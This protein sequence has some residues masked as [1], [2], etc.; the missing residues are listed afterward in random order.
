MH[1]YNSV[2]GEARARYRHL[3]LGALLVAGFGILVPSVPVAV[4]ADS[5]KCIEFLVER[6][7]IDCVD[8]TFFGGTVLLTVALEAEVVWVRLSNI[9]EVHVDYAASA[10]D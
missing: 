8:I 10:L 6:D 2:L 7:V 4:A 9:I 1:Q 5:H 3:R